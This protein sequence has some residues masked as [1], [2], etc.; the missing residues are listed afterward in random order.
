MKDT[1]VLKNIKMPYNKY[2]EQFEEA[3]EIYNQL[4]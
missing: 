1:N 4:F 3:K 2:H